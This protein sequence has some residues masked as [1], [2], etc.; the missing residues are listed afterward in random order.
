MNGCI[1]SPLLLPCQWPGLGLGMGET[2][3]GWRQISLTFRRLVWCASANLCSCQLLVSNFPSPVYS[4]SLRKLSRR[5]MFKGCAVDR[6]LQNMF[7][8]S[9]STYLSE[10]YANVLKGII[11]AFIFATRYFSHYFLL[12]I[13]LL[14]PFPPLPL[15][16]ALVTFAD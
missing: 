2:H 16:T 14:Y 9:C 7:G 11:Q 1:G 6:K 3:S 8:S 15:A 4:W 12:S 13:I 10:L 5:D